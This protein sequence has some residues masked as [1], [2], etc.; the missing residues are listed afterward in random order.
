MRERHPVVVDVGLGD[1][2]PGLEA[3][4]RSGQDRCYGRHPGSSAAV[5]PDGTAPDCIVL[6]RT[7]DGQAHAGM[8][9]HVRRA[10]EQLPVERALGGFC[11]I[12]EAVASAPGPLVELC[13]TWVGSA[14]RETDLAIAVVAGALAGARTLGARQV[15]GCSHQ[16]SLPL[17]RRFGA[18][19]DASLG[20]HAYPDERYRTCVVWADPYAC[21][22]EQTTVD[23]AAA[24]LSRGVPLY[25]D[26][27]PAAP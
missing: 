9:V 11:G 15:V 27:P 22:Q 21:G 12:A 20:I 24:Q 6:A 7:P 13:G 26:P 5:L 8:R 1:Q 14:F 10:G 17:Y 18:T 3:L 16:H 19:V 4:Y 2:I 23:A 25:F